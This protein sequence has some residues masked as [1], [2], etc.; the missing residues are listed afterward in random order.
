VRTSGKDFMGMTLSLDNADGQAQN[1]RTAAA[2]LH[3]IAGQIWH[4]TQRCHRKA[5]LVALARGRYR[6][7][8]DEDAM[9][10]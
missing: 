10:V 9:A 6:R 5:V 7:I 2:H 3:R 4:L 1:R 8:D